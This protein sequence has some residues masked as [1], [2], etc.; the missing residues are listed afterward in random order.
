MTANSPLPAGTSRVRRILS[1]TA[2]GV[3]QQVVTVAM[4]IALVPLI[5]DRTGSETVG[6]YAILMQLVGWGAITN[7]GLG[8]AAWRFMAEAYGVADGGVRFATIL[9]T[10]RFLYWI[11]NATFATFVLGAGAATT[12][13]VSLSPELAVQLRTA[14]A[15]YAAWS[16]LRTPLTLYGDA[17]YATQNVAIASLT[18]TLGTLLRLA[19]SIVLVWAGF[20]LIGLATAGI[21]SEF[22]TAVAN[23]VLFLRLQP[24]IGRVAA[25]Y[26]TAL[27]KRMLT[28]GSTFLISTAASLL[29]ANTNG[30]VFG[31]LL[32]AG[33]V[34]MAYTSQMPAKV[35][36]LTV[37]KLSDSAAPA[38]TQ[39]QGRSQW[40][41]LRRAYLT[42]LR[43]SLACGLALAVGL[44]AFSRPAI[45]LWVGADQYAGDVFTAAVAAATVIEIVLHLQFVFFIARG[46]IRGFGIAM[47][48][49]N[50][51]KIAIWLAAGRA[52][53]LG[54]MM[55]VDLAVQVPI[56]VYASARLHR[57][58][59]VTSSDVF[60]ESLLRPIVIV[61]GCAAFVGIGSLLL[62]PP[63][64]WTSLAGWAFAYSATWATLCWCIGCTSDERARTLTVLRHHLYRRTAPAGVA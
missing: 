2:A 1:G 54:G 48:V 42:L 61:A 33:A 4:Q 59:G 35:L 63:N 12:F 53:G 19:G 11:T 39:M 6:A 23:Y 52:I 50:L 64:H 60:R 25:G 57:S 20:G 26:D 14:A 58:L 3:V 18:A 43:S 5:I 24:E 10:T 30:L 15:L 21:I 31:G 45:A 62:P 55:I 8:V 44:L 51:L 34:S 29:S 49:A 9:R 13:L 41:D 22:L 47:L 7:L 38:V 27:M 28:F 46:E 37:W 17:L 16:V 32:G 40:A 36:G 56:V